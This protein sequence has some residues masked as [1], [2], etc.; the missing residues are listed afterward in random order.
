MGPWIRNVFWSAKWCYWSDIRVQW[1]G[2]K[3]RVYDLQGPPSIQS[4]LVTYCQEQRFHGWNDFPTLSADERNVRSPDQ[5][6]SPCQC[7]VIPTN[8]S[9]S[10]S[11]N[12]QP[13]PHPADRA[14]NRTTRY[15]YPRAASSAKWELAKRWIS[16]RIQTCSPTRAEGVTGEGEAQGLCS[17]L[18]IGLWRHLL[19]QILWPS[20]QSSHRTQWVNMH[21][22]QTWKPSHTDIHGAK[23]MNTNDRKL[24]LDKAK[25]LRGTRYDIVVIRRDL[26]YAQRAEL[27]ERRLN[28]QSQQ[29]VSSETVGTQ[30]SRGHPP[31]RH[32]DTEQPDICSEYTWDGETSG[33]LRAQCLQLGH[34]LIKLCNVNT[35]GLCSTLGL[36]ENFVSQLRI[37]VVGVTETHLTSEISTSFI[38]IPNYCLYV[39]I[40]KVP[41]TFT[42]YLAD[43]DWEFEL[44]LMSSD[45]SFE[46]L[47]R[48]VK[49]ATEDSI[50][51][52]THRSLQ[53]KPPWRRELHPQ[54]VLF[55]SVSRNTAWQSYALIRQWYGHC[56]PAALEAYGMFS[57]L[58]RQLQV[59]NYSVQ[60]QS[61]YEHS[62]IEKWKDNP[63]LLHAYINSTKSAPATVGPLKLTD[64]TMSPDPK[65]DVVLVPTLSQ[66]K[67]CL[68]THWEDIHCIPD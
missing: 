61:R 67:S 60:S 6:C 48:I 21:N 4:N 32:A 44:A 7:P 47:C 54:E 11:P 28:R 66:F 16:W 58:N 50:P 33:K 56:S 14:W 17:Y 18:W 10:F 1:W 8:S 45:D 31:W 13:T 15:V 43:I 26:T 19:L 23:I 37:N 41:L 22:L 12:Q 34:S 36:L 52:K 39:V 55:K 65:A 62:L 3:L 64:G 63:K 42:T 35:N 2:H 30:I 27:R 53:T 49:E 25:N 59:C 5:S 20:F 46:C 29:Q 68:D 24:V 40:M 57:G 51:L 38:S 9:P